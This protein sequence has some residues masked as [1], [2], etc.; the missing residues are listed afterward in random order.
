MRKSTQN[1]VLALIIIA[2]V[3][4]FFITLISAK[5][6]EKNYSNTY[7]FT[8][9]VCD[10]KNYCEDYEIK[11]EN[12]KLAKFSPTGFTIQ[13]SNDWTDPRTQEDVERLC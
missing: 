9:A 10:E 11:C 13:N 12:G 1:L 5:I 3:L 6:D 8:K 7:S 2:L 4:G